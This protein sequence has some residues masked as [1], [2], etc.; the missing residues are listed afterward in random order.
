[1]DPLF[2]RVNPSDNVAII[3]NPEGVGAGAAFSNGLRSVGPVPQSHKIALQA[4]AEGQPILRYG[5]VIGHAAQ[6]IPAGAWVREQMI[7]M[8]AAPRMSELPLA[9]EVPLALAP[10]E[11]YS[12]DGYRNADGLSLIHI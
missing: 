12:F 10:L 5:Q 6:D 1:M 11:G 8:P 7:L 4:L 2:V 3:V 9:T